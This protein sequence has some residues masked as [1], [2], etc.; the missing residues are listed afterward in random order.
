MARV[1]SVIQRDMPEGPDKYLTKESALAAEPDKPIVDAHFPTRDKAKNAAYRVNN[2]EREDWPKDRYF[3]VY[4]A[5]PNPKEHPGTD[6]MVADAWE[7]L[8]C[9]RSWGIPEGWQKEVNAPG[10][11]RRQ[12][13]DEDHDGGPVANEPVVEEPVVEEQ[14]QPT[15]QDSFQEPVAV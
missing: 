12:D 3:A 9:L 6:G 1:K 15:V 11:R 5:N 4:A 2:G 10:S 7:L 13:G 14:E 8:I